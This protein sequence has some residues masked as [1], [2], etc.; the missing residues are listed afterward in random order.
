MALEAWDR[1]LA[2]V[3]SFAVTCA[4]ARMVDTLESIKNCQTTQ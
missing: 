1:N 2:T 3:R 4:S